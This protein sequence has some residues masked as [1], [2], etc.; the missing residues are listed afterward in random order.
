[1]ECSEVAI[2]CFSL[3]DCFELRK[4][5]D[6]ITEHSRTLRLKNQLAIT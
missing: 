1:M 4:N 5:I 3:S 2:L 6:V